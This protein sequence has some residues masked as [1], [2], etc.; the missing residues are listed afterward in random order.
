M[1]RLINPDE[2]FFD[3]D[4]GAPLALGTLYF[5]EPNQDPETNPKAVYSDAALTTAI[6]AT[7]P[8]TADGKPQQFIYLKG[9][10]SLTVRDSGGA[11]VFTADTVSGSAAD[12]A[13][14]T[15]TISTMK[16]LNAVPGQVITLTQTGR[17]GQFVVKSGTPPSDPQEGIYVI[18]DNGN[19]CERS[20]KEF[21]T[22]DMFGGRSSTAIQAAFD[23]GF[24]VDLGPHKDYFLTFGLSLNDGQIIKSDGALFTRATGTGAFDMVTGTD[25]EV[26]IRGWWSM[27][28]NK[29]ADS[30]V[31]T[32]SS[33]RFC[34]FRFI[35]CTGY[36]EKLRADNT[37]NGEIQAE[38]I[39]GG[40][41]FEECDGLIAL[42]LRG[43]GNDGSAVFGYQSAM[44]CGHVY[45]SNNTGSGFT[46][47]GCDDGVFFDIE[48]VT[49]GYSGVSVN[50]LRMQ[51]DNL[52]GFGAA[53]GFANVAIGHDNAGNRAS[54]SVINGVKS[55]NS[56]GWGVVVAGSTNVKVTG[57]E[58]S[59]SA[60]NG[61][62]IRQN[63]DDV[64]LANGSIYGGSGNGLSVESGTNNKLSN[65]SI[66]GNN[67][68][69]LAVLNGSHIDCD[70]G[71]DIYGNATGLLSFT[72][73]INSNAST[74]S[75]Y[76]TC[77]D[78]FV[79]GVI[80][81]NSGL[82]MLDGAVVKNNSSENFRT[83]GGGSIDYSRVRIG[84]DALAGQFTATAATVTVPNDNAITARN[85]DI[86]PAN[87]AAR[88]L[89]A[90]V[91]NI[92]QG[93]TFDVNLNGTP[94]GSEIYFYNIL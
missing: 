26:D 1:S 11:V 61:V 20:E 37:V 35:R 42:N 27:D 82:V 68:N 58:V 36:V 47:F 89:T 79:D 44:T 80:S 66:H 92:V 54:D 90:F 5:G 34:G 86:R 87:S 63:S 28:G 24:P 70:V 15:A 22:P 6:S 8:L 64:L 50:G 56:L 4:T 85:I 67:S 45:T 25:I 55:Y 7:Q 81:A 19:Y 72:G 18:L 23:S 51:C 84:N 94:T 57:Y 40:I 62:E 16:G 75:F 71:C 77:R 43:K 13:L 65:S 74:C 31:R 69:G 2:Q 12:I 49:S 83:A 32:N 33:D 48:S 59:G 30:L 46:T 88:A 39:R 10:Y 29:D 52:R 3:N 73:N 91:G 17:A 76:G 41:M 53:N 93:A 9:D 60:E 21:V 38:G 14:V 78:S